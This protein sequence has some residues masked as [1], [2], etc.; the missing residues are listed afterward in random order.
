M[1]GNQ[2]IVY[3]VLNHLKSQKGR[4]QKYKIFKLNN[5]KNT[6]IASGTIQKLVAIII[7]GSQIMQRKWMI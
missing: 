4:Q 7:F 6:L 2:N 3:E 1:H 5:G